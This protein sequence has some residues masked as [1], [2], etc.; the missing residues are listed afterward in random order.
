MNLNQLRTLTSIEMNQN[1]DLEKF[2][3]KIITGQ[4]SELFRSHDNSHYDTCVEPKETICEQ[5][6]RNIIEPNVSSAQNKNFKNLIVHHNNYHS[7]LKDN[8][9]GK[10]DLNNEENQSA[11]YIETFETNHIF[12]RESSSRLSSNSSFSY[13][14]FSGEQL[15]D[16]EVINK[17]V[18]YLKE[19]IK[20]RTEDLKIVS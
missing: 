16:F 20:K 13:C 3:E 19:K 15:N 9:K 11:V 4:A 6:T 14:G 18:E 12:N 10:L 5:H 17:L 2:Q 7:V 8:L 1:D